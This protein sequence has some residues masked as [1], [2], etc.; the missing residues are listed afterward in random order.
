VKHDWPCNDRQ[1]CLDIKLKTRS[2]TSAHFVQKVRK[3]ELK[4]NL[5]CP[6]SKTKI[7]SGKW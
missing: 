6:L 3:F 2:E 5:K 1:S 7:Y 4:G